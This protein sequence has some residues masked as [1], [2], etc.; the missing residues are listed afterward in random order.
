MHNITRREFFAASVL[1]AL[2]GST[3]INAAHPQILMFSGAPTSAPPPVDPWAAIDGSLNAAIKSTGPQFPNALN[4]YGPGGVRNRNL[5]TYQPPWKVAGVDYPVGVNDTALPLKNVSSASLPSGV[6]RSGSQITVTGNN[7]VLDGYDFQFNTGSYLIIN[8]N[9]CTVQNCSFKYGS[10]YGS[11]TAILVNGSGA[12][13]QYCEF[14]GIKSAGATQCIQ[15]A[16]LTG[17][18][19]V[20]Y[21]WLYDWNDDFIRLQNEPSTSGV[22]PV[23]WTIRWN[24]MTNGGWSGVHFDCCQTVNASYD[25]ID[26]SFNFQMQDYTTGCGAATGFRNSD[27]NSPSGIAGKASTVAYCTI[28]GTGNGT[29]NVTLDEVIV[30]SGTNVGQLTNPICHDCYF[31]MSGLQSTNLVFYY[32]DFVINGVQYNNWDMARVLTQNPLNPAGYVTA[33][34][35]GG[36]SYTNYTRPN[37]PTFSTATKSGSAIAITGTCSAR[38]SGGKSTGNYIVNVFVAELAPPFNLIGTQSVAPGGAISLTTSNLS[39]G[40]YTVS[41]CV[42]DDEWNASDFPATKSV[43]I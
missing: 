5:T 9:N 11:N 18:G 10:N 42:V 37:P 15:F 28:I 33:R 2:L 25:F 34:Q 38:P 22:K 7:V 32:A 19:T 21:C 24:C 26:W 12:L 8:G 20:Q 17:T 4:S 43:T 6:S 39:A 1:G 14:N 36:V 41:I 30:W 29:T 31:D 3:Y 40:T 13:I 23:E 35:I 16:N 27:F